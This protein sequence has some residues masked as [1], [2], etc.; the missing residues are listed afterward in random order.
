MFL[1][2]GKRKTLRPKKVYTA[3]FHFRIQRGTAF[4]GAMLNG[5]K[6]LG[7]CKC[8]R[9]LCRSEASK[10]P[11]SFRGKSICTYSVFSGYAGRKERIPE[12]QLYIWHSSCRKPVIPVVIKSKEVFSLGLLFSHKHTFMSRTFDGEKT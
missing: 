9:Y 8:W 5:E 7:H 6:S 10:E 12:W 11:L 4:S 1:K 3:T 2:R